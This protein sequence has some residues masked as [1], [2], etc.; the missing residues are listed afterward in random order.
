M[1]TIVVAFGPI[2]EVRPT[3]FLPP[4]TFFERVV[5]FTGIWQ[6]LE[7]PVWRGN[8]SKADARMPLSGARR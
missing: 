2:A 1:T 4:G 5:F 7:Q 3:R 6:L 8:R